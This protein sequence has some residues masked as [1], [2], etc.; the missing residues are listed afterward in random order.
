MGSKQAWAAIYW[1]VAVSLNKSHWSD[2]KFGSREWG[3]RQIGR[4]GIYPTFSWNA[5]RLKQVSGEYKIS[6]WMD[7]LQN[8]LTYFGVIKNKAKEVHWPISRFL[9]GEEQ[10]YRLPDSWNLWVTDYGSY[11]WVWLELMRKTHSGKLTLGQLLAQLNMQIITQQLHW[12][13]DMLVC[14]PGHWKGHV[15]SENLVTC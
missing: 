9:K 14:G 2:Y 1:Q 3:L 4:K 15:R 7:S 6:L 13:S 8:I 5:R 10:E 12:Y 11:E